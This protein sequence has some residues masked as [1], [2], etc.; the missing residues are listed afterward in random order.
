[1]KLVKIARVLLV[2]VI[3]SFAARKLFLEIHH[4][5][6]FIPTIARAK[7]FWL[8]AAAASICLQYFGDGWL[9]K[10]L[11]KIT[12]H[13][14]DLKNTLKIAS[15]DVFA[16]HI[17][18]LGEAGVIATAALLYKKLGVSNQAI[19]FLTIAWAIATNLALVILLFISAIFLPKNPEIPIHISD[20]SL[21]TAIFLALLT[22]IFLL[23]RKF[24]W[25]LAK[26]KF[27]KF[28]LFKEIETFVDNFGSHLKSLKD[29]KILVFESILAAFT[30]Y[31]A[32][33][34]SLYFSFLA[35]GEPPALSV[36]AF[37][38]LISLV[39]SFIT[40]APAGIGVAEA[41]MFLVFSQ[42]GTN[43]ALALASIL[44][45]RLF[46]FWL[47]IPAGAYA[48]FSIKKQSEKQ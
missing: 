12:G 30:Y 5:S 34:A 3:V 42:F 11:L 45:F 7:P 41:T 1:M 35:F 25:Q 22:L 27:S 48:Y 8:F 32:Y 39:T 47:P 44:A 4:F 9:S 14:I 21:F 17:L 20:I 10:I 23:K 36:I 2:I 43:P 31:V 29:N 6:N 18:P 19:I 13:K 26:R 16:A 37:A 38:Y 15:I 46:A 33:I 28:T 40:L 24:F